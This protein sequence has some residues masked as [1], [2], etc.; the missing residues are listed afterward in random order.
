MLSN[1]TRVM[2]FY[3][4]FLNPRI[5]MKLFILCVFITSALLSS[6][7]DSPSQLTSN[8]YARNCQRDHRNKNFAAAEQECSLALT[9]NDWGNNPKIKSQR[10]YSLGVI[11]QRLGKFSEAELLLK[12]SLQIEEMLASSRKTVGSRL[13]ELSTSLAGQGKWEEGAPH[14]EKVIPIALQ[15]SKQERVRLGELLLQYH[16]HL[17]SMNKAVLAKQFKNTAAM[18]VDND[19]FTFRK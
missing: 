6:C 8:E 14:L 11:K 2:P 13:V 10:L 18:I 3:F 12:E 1:L 4:R 17:I 9:N 7:A 5:R 16:R 15:Y 19:T